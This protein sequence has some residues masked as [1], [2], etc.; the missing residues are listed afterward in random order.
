MF[1]CRLG[2]SIKIESV[3]LAVI[4]SLSPLLSLKG[5]A[6]TAWDIM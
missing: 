1:L 4:T 2:F 3:N 5:Q 6:L